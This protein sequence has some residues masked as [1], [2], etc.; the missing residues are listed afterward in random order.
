MAYPFDLEDLH[1][2]RNF[3]LINVPSRNF[4]KSYSWTEAVK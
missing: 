3:L 2:L 1:R 4:N